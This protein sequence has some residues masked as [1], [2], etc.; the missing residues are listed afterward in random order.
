MSMRTTREK[1]SRAS[2]GSELLLTMK[3]YA[4][5]LFITGF[6]NSSA[7][8]SIS[9]TNFVTKNIDAVRRMIETD[10][11]KEEASNLVWDIKIGGKIWIYYYNPK[12]N[13]QSTLWFY[14]DELKTTKVA[15]E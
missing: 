9:V 11:L 10:R 4:R 13:Q 15:C 14:R 8:V 6:Q 5:R 7:A 3:H 12:T 2:L 1:L